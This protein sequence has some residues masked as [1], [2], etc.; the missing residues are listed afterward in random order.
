MSRHIGHHSTY[1]LIRLLGIY[2]RRDRYAN[3]TFENQSRQLV[4]VFDCIKNITKWW[5][6][7]QYVLNDLENN[8]ESDEVVFDKALGT[9]WLQVVEGIR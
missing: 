1:L 8:M 3:A 2:K 4:W 5:N 7:L 9:V 6:I